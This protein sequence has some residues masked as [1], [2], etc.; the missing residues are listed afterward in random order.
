MDGLQSW[1]NIELKRRNVRD[2]D[3]AI[4]VAED[5]MEL[6]KE[7]PSKEKGGGDTSLQK[8]VGKRDNSPTRALPSSWIGRTIERDKKG[9]DTF[10]DGHKTNES[11]NNDRWRQERQELKCYLCDG[12]HWTKECP[13]KKVLKSLVCQ[14]EKVDGETYEEKIN[15]FIASR[16][17]KSGGLVY[18]EAKV[19]GGTKKVLIDSGGTHNFISPE[20]ARRLRIRY[21]KETGWIK[22]VNSA[23]QPIL[24]VACRI[25][26][27]LGEW[28]GTIDVII[29]SMDDCH[30]VLGVEFFHQVSVRI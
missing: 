19:N 24:G 17:P 3:E 12:A 23:T 27:H 10:G 18:V 14:L 2:V 1:A 8:I 11:H 7:F 5:L 26:I 6:K 21:T 25:P 22:A 28:T 16:R 20:K 9:H 30:M 15:S 29:T 4:A 13:Q